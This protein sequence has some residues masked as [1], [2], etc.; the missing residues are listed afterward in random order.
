MHLQDCRNYYDSIEQ[1]VADSLNLTSA[2]SFENKTSSFE[3]KEACCD[4]N[5]IYII[6]LFIFILLFV[7]VISK[8]YYSRHTNNIL[9][10]I[11]S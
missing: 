3:N 10:A 11:V 2:S 6:L 7:C 4:D 9:N 1:K 8:C 5:S